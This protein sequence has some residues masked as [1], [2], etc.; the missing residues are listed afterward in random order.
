[1][2]V[3]GVKFRSRR[4][5]NFLLNFFDKMKHR[6]VAAIVDT[7]VDT[8]VDNNVDNN[9]NLSATSISTSSIGGMTESP[10]AAVHQ[11]QKRHQHFR[12]KLEEPL[13][14]HPQQQQQQPE[15]Q[16]VPSSL[17]NKKPQPVC[18]MKQCDSSLRTRHSQKVTVPETSSALMSHSLLCIVLFLSWFVQP[19][20]CN[21]PPRFVLESSNAEVVGGDIVVRLKEGQ[22]TPTGSKIYSLKGFDADGDRLLFGVQKGKDSDLI[23]VVNQVK[24]PSCEY[25]EGGC[26]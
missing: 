24:A 4:R 12:G 3:G 16:S 13:L 1:M 23:K 8:N 2:S 5:K 21:S 22:E 9:T 14:Q 6:G 19:G 17:H 26:V 10:V 20:L 25:L 15:V 18:H 7:D 11:D